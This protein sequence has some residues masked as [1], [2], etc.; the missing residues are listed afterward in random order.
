[1]RVALLAIVAFIGGFVAAYLLAVIAALTFV[2]VAGIFDRE[3]AL[4]M[5]IVFTIGPLAGLLGGI[6]A[7]AYAVARSRRRQP[8]PA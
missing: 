2:E 4:S 7:A 3:G 5:G 6:A 1:M 8:P